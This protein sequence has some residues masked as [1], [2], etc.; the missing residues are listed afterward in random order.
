MLYSW[1]CKEP[2][3]YCSWV[4]LCC[5]D[6]L[7][8]IWCLGLLVWVIIDLHFI[9]H[10][11][12]RSCLVFHTL[13]CSVGEPQPQFQWLSTLPH[14]DK[15]PDPCPPRMAWRPLNA[16]W[17]VSGPLLQKKT[18]TDTITFDQKSLKNTSCTYLLFAAAG[19]LSKFLCRNDHSCFYVFPNWIW[20][21]RKAKQCST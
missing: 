7:K 2:F 14:L 4:V 11:L 21:D 8:H 10:A 17:E 12:Y 6:A 19:P 9:L 3:V 18:E 20:C 16:D 1:I 15:R 13:T 5:S